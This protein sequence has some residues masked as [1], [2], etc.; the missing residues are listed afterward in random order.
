MPVPVYIDKNQGLFPMR[1][2]AELVDAKCRQP[3]AEYS[4]VSLRWYRD[5]QG[6]L[7]CG[8]RSSARK[9][10]LMRWKHRLPRVGTD[11]QATDFVGHEQAV[12][13]KEAHALAQ[14]A[15]ALAGREVLKAGWTLV[16][17]GD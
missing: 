12:T 13:G 17:R 7:F 5:L 10:A 8:P 15:I 3:L 4:S 16:K 9:Q 6:E 11:R 1:G 14:R 2:L